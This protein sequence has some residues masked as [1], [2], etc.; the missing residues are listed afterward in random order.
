MQG[1]LAVL[2]ALPLNSQKIVFALV[3]MQL[4]SGGATNADL[5]DYGR[6][7]YLVTSVAA[8]KNIL[9]GSC[10][11]CISASP[12]YSLVQAEL[13]DHQMLRTRKGP[14]GTQVIV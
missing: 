10:L 14:D 9:V 12:F 8:L 11:P 2:R 1:S 13:R 6:Q 5:H 4:A 7:Y 3:R